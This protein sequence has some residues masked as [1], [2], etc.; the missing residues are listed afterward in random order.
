[1]PASV[2]PET[3]TTAQ[4]PRLEEQERIKNT[5]EATSGA[6]QRIKLLMDAWCALWFYPVHQAST[7]P[8]REAWLAMAQVLLGGGRSAGDWCPFF[9][10]RLGVDVELLFQ[11]GHA[12]LPD[13]KTLGDLLPWLRILSEIGARER[14]FHW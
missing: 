5:L 1:M 11:A 2:W 8:T 13:T 3:P 6:F 14:F 7:L 12:D 9:S 4:G 10:M